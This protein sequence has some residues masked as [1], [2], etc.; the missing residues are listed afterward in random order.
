MA[1]WGQLAGRCGCWYGSGCCA[2]TKREWKVFHGDFTPFILSM[3]KALSFG[4]EQIIRRKMLLDDT[5]K[6]ETQLEGVNAHFD[7]YTIWRPHK[8]TMCTHWQTTN[9]NFRVASNKRQ[10]KTQ[11]NWGENVHAPEF[12]GQSWKIVVYCV[13]YLPPLFKTCQCSG[14]GSLTQGVVPMPLLFNEKPQVLFRK[15]CCHER[16]V[17]DMVCPWQGRVHQSDNKHH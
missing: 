3:E 8:N 14:N 5:A 15:K 12:L 13:N 9:Y 6:S 4:H 16:C 17:N 10:K 1:Q 11:Q 2:G 7:G